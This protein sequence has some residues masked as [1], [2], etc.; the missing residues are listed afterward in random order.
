MY[1]VATHQNINMAFPISFS[2]TLSYINSIN[3]I[4]GNQGDWNDYIQEFDLKHFIYADNKAK[5]G[6][7][8]KGF[9]LSVGF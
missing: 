5:N 2:T 1:Y 8:R 4:N 7:S 6:Q 9:G 3:N